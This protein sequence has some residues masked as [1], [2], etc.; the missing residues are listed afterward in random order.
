MRP[1]QSRFAGLILVNLCLYRLSDV[2]R[3][4]GTSSK[5]ISIDKFL[6]LKDFEFSKISQWGKSGGVVVGEE[7]LESDFRNLQL[8]LITLS[9]KSDRVVI[10]NIRIQAEKFL[11]TRCSSF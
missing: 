8:S 4:L 6:I 3:E 10:E 5:E 1:W 11:N 2:F 9:G 7:K